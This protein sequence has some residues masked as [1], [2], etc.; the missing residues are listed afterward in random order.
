M[1]IYI[2]AGFS[3]LIF[4]VEGLGFTAL[5][6]AVVGLQ[7]LR[8]VVTCGVDLWHVGVLHN[9]KAP[10]SQLM[11]LFRPKYHNLDSSGADPPRSP[12]HPGTQ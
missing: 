3:F 6:V 12:K 9:P 5:R 10:S 4:G 11:G 2:Y 1:Y 8:R 7:R